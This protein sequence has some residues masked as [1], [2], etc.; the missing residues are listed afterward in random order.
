MLRCRLVAL[1][2]AAIVAIGAVI[3][4]ANSV[5]A[6]TPYLVKDIPGNTGSGFGEAKA[7]GS[8]LYFVAD[9]GIHGSELWKTDGTAAGTVLVKDILEGSG[10]SKPSNLTNVNGTLFFLAEPYDGFAGLWKTDGTTGGTV[11]V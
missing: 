4:G 10:S 6:Q 3:G 1:G 5:H 8:T 9:D 2:R 11:M 7:V